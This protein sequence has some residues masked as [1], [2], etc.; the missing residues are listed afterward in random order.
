MCF[1]KDLA[2]GFKNDNYKEDF[3]HD[4]DIRNK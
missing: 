3:K 2:E 1:Y 4:I